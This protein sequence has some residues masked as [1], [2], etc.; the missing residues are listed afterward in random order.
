[1]A[2]KAMLIPMKK[3]KRY[4]Q[5][6]MFIICLLMVE[7]VS[8]KGFLGKRNMFD[9]DVIGRSM[10][11]TH[12]FGYTRIKSNHFALRF[13]YSR[14]NFTIY[15]LRNNKV[16]EADLQNYLMP[17]TSYDPIWLS[18]SANPTFKANTYS[19]GFLFSSSYANL[20][21][22]VGYF[23]SYTFY[24]TKGSA[25]LHLVVPA[26]VVPFIASGHSKDI[27]GDYAFT[28]LGSTFDLGKTYYIHPGFTISLGA[29]MGA[30]LR[31][32]KEQFSE[33]I[34]IYNKGIAP[35]ANLFSDYPY[36]LPKQVPYSLNLTD[37]NLGIG[38]NFMPFLRFGYLF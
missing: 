34:T 8:G 17:S 25:S 31:F 16:F 2:E 19:L 20:N 7:S 9:Y 22:P 38:F 28:T 1:M 18:A 36:T 4:S 15:G 11:N 21:L 13:G 27:V 12:S 32:S 35:I 23:A 24:M 33:P 14:T 3:I 30:Y 29:Q 26:E 5:V 6:G 10:S 37:D